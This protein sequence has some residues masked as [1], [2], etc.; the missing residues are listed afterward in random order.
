[1]VEVSKGRGERIG[2]NDLPNAI[3]ARRV[4][5]RTNSFPNPEQWNGDFV[6]LSPELILHLHKV[7]VILVGID[8]PSVDPADSKQ[9]ESHQ[10]LWQ[11]KMGVLEGLV[12]Q[13]VQPGIYLLS[14]L[15]LKIEGADAGPVRAVLMDFDFDFE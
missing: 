1:M 12:L 15:P 3:E 4:L 9:L 13:D 6:A 5:F 8:T 2:I 10:A 11:T 7:G 14:A